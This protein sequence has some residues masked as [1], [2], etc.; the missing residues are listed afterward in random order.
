M[1]SARDFWG[2]PKGKTGF[3][4]GQKIFT[5][6][7]RQA[8]RRKPAPRQV[9]RKEETNRR[10]GGGFLAAGRRKVTLRARSAG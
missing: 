3:E 6:A 9:S 8:G 1:V 5:Q 10:R 7:G 4:D 2:R